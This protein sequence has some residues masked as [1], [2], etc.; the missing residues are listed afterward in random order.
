MYQ[1]QLVTLTFKLIILILW[2]LGFQR[3]IKEVLEE[4]LRK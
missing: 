1:R 4:K 2:D 3:K